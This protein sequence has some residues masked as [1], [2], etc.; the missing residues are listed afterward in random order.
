M[1]F[2]IASKKFWNFSGKKC[3]K[4]DRWELA[5]SGTTAFKI[6]AAQMKPIWI[7]SEHAWAVW[8]YV[9]NKKKLNNNNIER[10]RLVRPDSK[11]TKTWAHV[12]RANHIT[13]FRDRFVWAAVPCRLTD[14][15]GILAIRSGLHGFTVE[16]FVVHS[17][18]Y[19]FHSHSFSR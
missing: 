1:L 3:V 18:V 9:E 8:A 5:T 17:N 13:R 19:A 6:K 2:I 14:I 15:D 16:L 7:Y 10:T 4:L 11:T 12:K